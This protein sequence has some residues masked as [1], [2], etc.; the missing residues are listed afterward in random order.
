MRQVPVF[1]L[2]AMV[3]FV[4]DALKAQ[5]T[6]MPSDIDAMMARLAQMGIGRVSW[7]YYGDG[8]GGMICPATYL[9]DYQGG[10]PHCADTYRALG[11]PL[12][13]A[14]EAGHRHGLEVYAYFKPYETGP[15]VLFPAGSPAARENGLLDHIGG[16]LGWMDPF[17]RDNPTLRIKRRTDDLSPDVLDRPIR[18]LRLIKSDA[19]PTRITREHLQIW[20]SPNNWQYRQATL[21]F[22]FAQSVHKAPGEVR[23]NFGNLVTA[24][25]DEV[26]V[27]TLDGLNLRDKHIL[28]TT[29]FADG[30]DFS[31]SGTAILEALDERGHA[32]PGVLATGGT[33]WCGGLMDFRNAGLTFDYGWGRQQVT[34][35]AAND[36]GKKGFIA[37]ARGR[38][39]YLPG[40][41]CEC[42][43]AVRHFWLACLEEMIAAGVDGVD[44]REENHSTHTDFPQDYG[45]NDVILSRCGNALGEALT[46]KIAQV[47]GDAYTEFL[48]ACKARLAAADKNMR[49]NLQ[50]DYFRP[51]PPASRLLAYPL[52]LQFQWQRWIAEGLLDGIILRSYSLPGRKY[53][54][55][56]PEVLADE[57]AKE[58]I[59]IGMNQA[60]PI[61]VNRYVTA[62]GELRLKDEVRHVRLDGR[63]NGV[64]FYETCDYLEFKAVGQCLVSRPWVA[65]AI[66]DR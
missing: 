7:A 19:A 2:E 8:H 52:N 56:L 35:D 59:R 50:A 53:D 16:R 45:F 4:D 46:L 61:A 38:N 42:E 40:A 18:K 6:L 44:F 64:I 28:V 17:V 54:T 23:D 66:Q 49:Y 36:N 48:R 26:R 24:A 27:L 30:G 60:L 55:A 33:V 51:D 63:F 1:M 9:T 15:G 37:Y 43:P 13:V 32:I 22:G 21:D 3:D 29:D 34:L 20:T 10:W 58:M 12:K 39:A 14:V 41:L 11:N 25:G 62:A 31:N 5:R 47:R 65:C 57:V